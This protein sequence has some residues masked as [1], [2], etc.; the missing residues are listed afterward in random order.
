VECVREQ[1][2]LSEKAQQINARLRAIVTSA[3]SNAREFEYAAYVAPLEDALA[4]L[5]RA[6]MVG[7]ITQGE[8]NAVSAEARRI[9]RD[10]IARA[11][12]SLKSGS[13]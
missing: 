13:T 3:D 9:H 11:S 4:E 10:F 6:Q 12:S 2:E 7:K 5:F 8:A 1:F